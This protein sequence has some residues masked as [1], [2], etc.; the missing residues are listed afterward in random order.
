M[1]IC[2]TNSVTSSINSSLGANPSHAFISNPEWTPIRVSLGKE[3]TEAQELGITQTSLIV[4]LVLR[5]DCT[6]QYPEVTSNLNYLM[7]L[8]FIFY[9][10]HSGDNTHL[11]FSMLNFL[12][13]S[14]SKTP[15]QVGSYCKKLW[16]R[17]WRTAWEKIKKVPKDKRPETMRGSLK[18]RK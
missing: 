1:L 9:A 10:L 16:G 5:V 12:F 15:S 6:M 17:N 11:P 3:L 4:G 8:L 18:L 2:D 14:S 13:N 7:N